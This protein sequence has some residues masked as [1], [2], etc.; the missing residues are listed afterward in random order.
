MAGLNVVSNEMDHIVYV[1]RLLWQAM[2]R[3]KP[4]YEYTRG[5][6][7]FVKGAVLRCV[8]D[9]SLMFTLFELIVVSS[10]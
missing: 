9:N 4:G 8:M 7:R 5:G 6:R 1:I 3:K 10:E 2:Q